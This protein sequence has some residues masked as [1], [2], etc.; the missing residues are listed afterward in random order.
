MKKVISMLLMVAMVFT[1][2][3]CGSKAPA[4]AGVYSIET[5]EIEGEVLDRATIEEFTAFDLDVETV[6]LDDHYSLE[7]K[8]DGTFSL[9]FDGDT[10]DGDYGDG[11][12]T[13]EGED[14][15]YTYKDGTLTL[16]LYGMKLGFKKK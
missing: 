5:M 15:E 11:K 8:E 16:D 7:M 12:M 3:A 10:A 6:N 13:I 14:V 9:N 2:V 1:L 4:E